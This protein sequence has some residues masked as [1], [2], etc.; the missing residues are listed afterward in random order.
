[1]AANVGHIVE[2][3]EGLVGLGGLGDMTKMAVFCCRTF[4]NEAYEYSS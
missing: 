4:K 3:L 1:M 2:G